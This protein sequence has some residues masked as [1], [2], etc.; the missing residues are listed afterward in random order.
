MSTLSEQLAKAKLLFTSPM[1]D[2]AYLYQGSMVVCLKG[3]RGVV[4]TS[5]LN[6]GYRQDIKYLFNHS[7]ANHPDVRAKR[8]TGMKGNTMLDHYT[9][10][11]EELLL[12]L[13]CST[14]MSTAA[15]VENL[16][17]SRRAYHGVEVMAV[18]TAGV[19]VNAGRAG[20]PAP[21]DEFTNTDLLQQ[22][23][24]NL[25]LFVDAK[26]D[27]G[28]L[29]R[30]VLTATEAKTAALLELMVNSMYSED[31]ATGTGTDSVIVLCNDE[32]QQRLYNAGKHVLLGEMIGQT[33]KEA[34]SKALA[35]QSDLTPARQASI[36]WQC[37]RYGFTQAQILNRCIKLF[38]SADREAC[39]T[40]LPQ[41][42]SD[43]DLLAALAAICQ[44]CDQCRWQILSES[45][46]LNLAQT[47]ID[48]LCR[49]ECLGQPFDLRT[50]IAEGT[51]TH[52]SKIALYRSVLDA[53][54][55]LL[56]HALHR[57]SRS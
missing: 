57:R 31:L 51:S 52:T 20:E 54:L 8:S 55:T 22:G 4:S 56:A 35:N 12:P 19:D 47:L 48:S 6:G 39:K 37:K 11:A 23:T 3:N 15:R 42:D 36:E 43:P 30:A 40:A 24:I 50:M 27:A 25:I 49:K 28:V 38:P 9:A 53:F 32:S 26:L 14:G 17:L 13:D 33:V 34:I 1:G 16:A 7:C 18:A 2:E 45:A 10:L 44:L 21:F 29:T 46:L 5:N 41:L